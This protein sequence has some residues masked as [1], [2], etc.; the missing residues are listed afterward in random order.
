MPF[1]AE[2]LL[3]CLSTIL[4]VQ[5]QVVT[6]TRINSVPS[7]DMT[8]AP[9]ALDDIKMNEDASVV[10]KLQPN[11]GAIGDEIQRAVNARMMDDD[12]DDDDV[13]VPLDSREIGV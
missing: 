5:N 13:Q 4:A 9:D 12:D 1:S 10:N 2:L 8:E 7:G 6:E 11:S 3:I